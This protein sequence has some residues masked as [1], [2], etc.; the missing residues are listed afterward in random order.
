MSIMFC[1]KAVSRGLLD[2][3][4]LPR[5]NAKYKI[6]TISM[7]VDRQEHLLYEVKVKNF[8]SYVIY[9]YIMSVS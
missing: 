6:A 9:I 8:L 7:L 1:N 3:I 5:D 2:A 4:L